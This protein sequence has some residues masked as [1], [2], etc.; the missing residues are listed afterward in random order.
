MYY[1]QGLKKLY[2]GFGV[3]AVHAGIL[4]GLFTVIYWNTLG[5][6]KKSK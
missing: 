2:S 6:L 3:H 1:N 5:H 4:N